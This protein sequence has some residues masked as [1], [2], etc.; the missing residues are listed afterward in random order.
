MV[1]DAEERRRR[2]R[3]Y[4]KKWTKANPEK[5]KASNDA[6]RR[7][8]KA[9]VTDYQRTWRAANPR[10]Q[11]ASNK[12]WN[13]ANPEKARA[14][15]RKLRYGM[16]VA[17]YNAKCIE[18][19]HLCAICGKKPTRNLSIDHNHSTGKVRDLLCN[20][21][22]VGI[23]MFQEDAGRLQQAIAYLARHA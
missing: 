4:Q 16:T 6:W 13:D 18:Q 11:V 23:G 19:N 8:N 14:Y 10:S 15:Q 17:E 20:Q 1:I 12:K 3:E 21:C 9:K 22:N 7:K 5:V 2:A